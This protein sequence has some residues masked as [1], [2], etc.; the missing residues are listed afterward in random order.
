MPGTSQKKKRVYGGSPT[1]LNESKAPVDRL[2][3]LP[4]EVLVRIVDFV[5]EGKGDDGE[6]TGAFDDS[7]LT[8]YRHR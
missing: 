1:T 7:S 5:C 3:T 4:K 6:D 8:R 2:S